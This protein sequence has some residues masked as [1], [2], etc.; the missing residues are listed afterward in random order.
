MVSLYIYTC[1][2]PKMSLRIP[3]TKLESWPRYLRVQKRSKTARSNFKDKHICLFPGSMTAHHPC[4][5][6]PQSRLKKRVVGAGSCIPNLGRRKTPN[7]E[8][9][10]GLPRL[11]TRLKR[12]RTGE[13]SLGIVGGDNQHTKYHK[14][15]F[16]RFLT[17]V[18]FLNHLLHDMH[19]T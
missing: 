16:H 4:F 11:K 10:P 18:T 13:S 1:T 7:Q 2:I 19:T 14:L 17:L 6:I 5:S 15:D 8:F 12:S 3:G 9:S